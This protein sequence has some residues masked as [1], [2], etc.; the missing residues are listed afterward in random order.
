MKLEDMPETFEVVLTEAHVLGSGKGCF[1]CPVALAVGA[2]LERLGVEGL[3]PQ[4]V[5]VGDRINI[6]GGRAAGMRSYKI[7]AA[8]AAMIRS[9]DRGN[10]MQPVTFDALLS[11]HY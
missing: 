9:F 3:E 2:A 7:P 10:G 11:R 6:Y 5:S 1:R 4:A 8:V